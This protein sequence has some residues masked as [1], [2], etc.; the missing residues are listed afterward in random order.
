M[1]RAI[2]RLPRAT[3]H[4]VRTAALLRF[5][6]NWLSHQGDQNSA[7]AVGALSVAG[8]SHGFQGE[9]PTTDR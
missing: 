5:M 2:R 4:A 1:Q 7:K 8:L 3:V 6:A 9:A